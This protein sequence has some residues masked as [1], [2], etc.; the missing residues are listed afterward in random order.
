MRVCVGLIMLAAFFYSCLSKGECNC[1]LIKVDWL[2]VYIALR[3]VGTVLVVILRQWR[4]IF[5]I[6][7]PMGS[8][9]RYL[10][11]CPEPC[12]PIRSKEAWMKYTLI[13]LLLTETRTIL[14]G[15]HKLR[16]RRTV[17]ESVF[18]FKDINCWRTIRGLCWLKEPWSRRFG[19][20]PT[21][22]K[23]LKN[24]SEHALR[25]AGSMG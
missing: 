10:K 2:D 7:Q 19:T 23:S 18:F 1:S 11:K 25:A 12:W 24:D 15:A 13:T 20:L 5:T 16:A 6:L 21:G 3:V 22:Q 14:L 17:C 4:K 8:K 9:G